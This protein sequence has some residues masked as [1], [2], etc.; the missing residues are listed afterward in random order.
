MEQSKNVFEHGSTWLR[1]DFH[2]HTQSDDEFPNSPDEPTFVADYIDQMVNTDTRIGVITNHNKFNREEFIKLKSKGVQKGIGLFP[3]IEFSLAEGIHILIVFDEEWYKGEIDH[4]NAFLQSAFLGIPHPDKAKGGYP[5]SRFNLEKA[6]QELE[7]LNKGYFLLLAHV[8]DTNGLFKVLKG[9]TLEAFVKS[10]SFGKVLGIQ[11]SGNIENYKKL[12]ELVGK[13]LACIHGSDHAQAGI[14]GIGTGTHKVY[15]K[16]GDFSFEALKYALTDH[17]YRV[18]PKE[19]PEVKNSYIKSI[20]FEGGLLDGKSISF[21]PEL[22]NF[23]GIR[24][25]GKS[26]I[27][28]ILRYTLGISLNSQTSDYQYK[29]GLVEHVI[30]SGGKII[31]YLVNEH[32]EEYR[33][34]K[35]YGQKENIYKNEVLQHNI[36]IDAF[37]KRPVYFGQKDLSNKESDFEADLIHRLIGSKL[38]SIKAEIKSKQNEIEHT[39]L[40]INKLKDLAEVKTSAEKTIID[41]EHKLKTY[42]EQGVEQKLKQQ[43]EFESDK[44]RLKQYEAKLE[45]FANN[46]QEL[47]SQS[48]TFESELK[49]SELTK[50]EYDLAN[51]LIK[52]FIQQTQK[53]SEISVDTTKIYERF[54]AVLSKIHKKEESLKEEFAKIKREINLPTL[55]PDNFLN[56]NRQIQTAKMKLKEVE[57]SEAKKKILNETLN[58]R[59]TEL[60]DLWLKEY[61]QLEAEVNKINSAETKLTIE[62]KFKGNRDKFID[63]LKQISKG[64]NIF[65]TTYPDISNKYADFV[66]IYRNPSPLDE[67][68]NQNQFVDFQRRFNEHLPE[69]LTYKVENEVTIKYNGKPLKDHS[70]GQR[71]SALILFLLAQKENDVLIIDQPE[72]DLDNQTIYRDVIQEIRNLKGEMQFVFATH[73]ANIPVLGDS[74]KVIA[75]DYIENE[76]IDLQIGTIDD[77]QIQKRI[78]DVMEGGTRAFNLRKQIYNIWNVKE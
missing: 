78:V 4:I 10:D 39:I 35:I 40:E 5:N 63:K 65:K 51:Q 66:E 8:D 2:L 33:I 53:L 9:R 55:S 41:N 21:S 25:S 14:P 61:R 68:L 77:H 47:A 48:L 19:K 20:V 74:E 17:E 32:E 69:L 18:R 73:N 6:V 27:L 15:L 30:R 70:L 72:D 43:T 52:E 38:K 60:N 46:L 36:S 23:I 67:L 44:G 1:A 75:C 42:A 76:E 59:L 26:S 28:E 3:G 58:Q 24:G 45:F 62:I 71:A 12:T 31:L 64:A 16:V 7:E 11:K 57:K 56:L 54:R 22:N 37:F 29:N 49:G 13:K 50:E 34:E